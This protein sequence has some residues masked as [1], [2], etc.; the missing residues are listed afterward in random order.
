M[1][2]VFLK[3]RDNTI[4]EATLGQ[5]ALTVGR[6]SGNDIQV[7]NPAVSGIHARIWQE[8]ETI[9]IEDAESTNGTY[10]NGEKIIKVALN[11]N[12][13]VLIGKH[14]LEIKTGDEAQKDEEDEPLTPVT[15]SLDKTMILD[16]KIRRE[17][18]SGP[19][20]QKG[21]FVVISGSAEAKCYELS[22][23][24]TTIGKSSG[25]LIKIKG[26]FAPKTVALINKTDKGYTI[27]PVDR[28]TTVKINGVPIAAMQ[29]MEDKDLVEVYG[30][31]LQF[32]LR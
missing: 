25:S 26:L 21:E 20:K 1:A 10:V 8:G 14:H 12:D 31:T 22:D 9:F 4:S 28:K 24:V 19:K 11:E 5:T 27:T 32:H 3:F 16:S 15:P 2:K 7:D 6:D 13:E 23:R 30:L 18:T 29:I 17:M